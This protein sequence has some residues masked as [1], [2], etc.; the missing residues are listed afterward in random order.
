[1]VHLVCTTTGARGLSTHPSRQ[2]H[3]SS[4]LPRRESACK[5]QRTD[6]GA[7]EFPQSQ[8]ESISQAKQALLSALSVDKKRRKKGY[9]LWPGIKRLAVEI[10]IA[11][12]S[13]A[14]QLALA[15]D[16][17]ST[18]P[19]AAGLPAVVFAS[20]AVTDHARAQNVPFEVY[21]LAEAM[22]DSEGLEGPLMLF[23]AGREQAADCKRIAE[24]LWRGKVLLVVNAEWLRD[25]PDDMRSFAEALEPVYFFMPIAFTGL[26]GGK[27]GFVFRWSESST[28]SRFWKIFLDDGGIRSIGRMASK[29]TQADLETAV[30]NASA[31]KSPLAAGAK[32]VNKLTKGFKK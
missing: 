17:L 7:E 23:G 20:Q 10:P 28:D 16:L 21:S 22:D 9:A 29:P 6:L 13:P 14:A 18:L 8:E 24:E 5:A 1:M 3:Q 15:R 30:Y 32:L 11:D 12:D 27:T 2:V 25:L 31:A 4:W 19:A 26:L